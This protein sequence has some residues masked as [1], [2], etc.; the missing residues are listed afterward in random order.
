LADA[1]FTSESHVLPECVGNEKQQVLPKGVVC[2]RCNQHFG[3]KIEPT[4][5]NDPIFKTAVGILQLRDKDNEFVYKH[6]LSG[7]H[8]DV[9]MDIKISDYQISV[10]TKYEVKD[11]PGKA[12][13][14][15]DISLKSKVYDK[16]SFAFLSRAVHKIAFESLA[17][18]LY[19]KNGAEIKNPEMKN[20]DIFDHSFDV[21]RK[22]ARYGEP[23][24]SVR[25]FLRLYQFGEVQDQKELF[26]WQYWL[27]KF[28][29]WFR[30]EMNLYGDCYVVSLTSSKEQVE[31]DLVKF[32][33]QV[34]SNHPVLIIGDKLKQ[35]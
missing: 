19:V 32:A 6:S 29:H 16:K 24:D 18:S 26:H 31:T 12:Y 3:K 8:R 2:D 23:S 15:R 33:E 4:F 22:W 5:I 25:P 28:K 30:F 14:D 1:T 34:K 13:E 9:H 35:I 10:T 27:F 11:Q 21:I 17:F 7:V 20:L